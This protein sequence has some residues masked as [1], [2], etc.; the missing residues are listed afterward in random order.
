MNCKG[1][2]LPYFKIFWK[3]IYSGIIMFNVAHTTVWTDK[4]LYIDQNAQPTNQ[5]F[6]YQ[7]VNHRG[8]LQGYVWKGFMSHAI[9]SFSLFD[10]H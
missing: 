3:I 8:A 2:T 1:F 6:Q 9:K 7:P 10:F 5:K 4:K